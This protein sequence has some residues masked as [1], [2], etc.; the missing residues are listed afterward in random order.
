MVNGMRRLAIDTSLISAAQRGDLFAMNELLGKLCPYVSSIC[1]PIALS[2][3]A[4]ATQES[5]IM[6][7]R[8]LGRLREPDALLGWVRIIATREAVR[9][10]KR[11]VPE[12]DQ[13][14]LAQRAT[15]ENPEVMVDVRHVLGRLSPQHRAVLV[16]REIE[17]FDDASIAAIL[18]VPCGTVKSRL[19]RARQRFRSEWQAEA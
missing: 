8:G 2:D 9:I 4:D 7:F 10:A 18:S 15:A 6:I 16:L 14:S 11:R 1:G 17:G 12:P 13:G 19:N 3:A 5:L